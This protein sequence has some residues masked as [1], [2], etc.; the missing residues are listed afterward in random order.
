M[1]ESAE[2][3]KPHLYK[4]WAVG[5]RPRPRA[6]WYGPVFTLPEG[7]RPLE[8]PRHYLVIYPAQPGQQPWE[9]EWL[10]E[11]DPSCG[12]NYSLD[13][14]THVHAVEYTCDVAYEVGHA[15]LDCLGVDEYG[16]EWPS[17]P[18][19]RYEVEAYTSYGGDYGEEADRG[20]RVVRRVG[21]IVAVAISV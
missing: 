7:Y 8:R 5:A 9:R 13:W 3:Y 10:I 15:G 12:F 1:A 17:L 14:G 20:F 2:W 21:G 11:H 18:A 4:G 6:I 16:A 19:G